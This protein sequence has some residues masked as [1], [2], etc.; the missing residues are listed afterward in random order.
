MTDDGVLDSIDATGKHGE[1]QSRVE[2]EVEEHVPSL[3]ADADR[4]VKEGRA[5]TRQN[6]GRRQRKK[7]IFLFFRVVRIMAELNRVGSS[8]RRVG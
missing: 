2:A 8:L 4:A 5:E 1:G 3:P 7:S 6:T